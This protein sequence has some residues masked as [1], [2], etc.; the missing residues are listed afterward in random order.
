VHDDEHQEHE[1]ESFAVL[2]LPGWRHPRTRKVHIRRDCPAV[3]YHRANMTP[4]LVRLD[5][6]GEVSRVMN[7]DDCCRFCFTGLDSPARAPRREER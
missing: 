4:F 5:D 1:A 2:L 6:E 7:N 3:Y